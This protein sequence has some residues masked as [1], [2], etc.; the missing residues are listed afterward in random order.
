MLK[1]G[2]QCLGFS[3]NIKLR[4]VPFGT[5]LDLKT[6]TSHKCEVVPRRAHI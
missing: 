1:V 6:T 3:K 4:V 2:V 5:V